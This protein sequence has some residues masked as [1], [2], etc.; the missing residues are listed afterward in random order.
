[1]KKTL[2][3]LFSTG[4]I[5]YPNGV[6]KKLLLGLIL[7]IS[8]FQFY[9][10]LF[11]ILDPFMHNAIFITLMLS[12]AFIVY[13]AN[14]N[15]KKIPWIDY[16]IS[17]FLCISTIFFT[18]NSERFLT[19]WP[20]ADLLTPLEIIMG[21]TLILI[22]I[23]IT[24]RTLGFG[25]LIIVLLLISYSFFGHLIPG[26]FGH[27]EISLMQ[28]IDQMVYTVNGI[29]GTIA[30]VAATYV[31]FFVFFG[32]VFNASGGGDFFYAISK[33]ITGR[34]AGG[35]AKVAVISS[36]LYGSIS[37]S[38]TADV[39][40]T[41]SFTIP[42]MKKVGYSPIYAGAIEATAATGGSILPP[43]MGS[44]AF[45]M[46][47]ITGIPY[48]SIAIAALVPALLYY[49]AIF[50]QVH[51][52][53][54]KQNMEGYGENEEI[55][56][57]KIVMKQMGQYIIPILVLVVFLERGSSPV[58][59]AVYATVT[60]I[61]VSYFKKETRMSVK[62]IFDTLIDTV[63]RISP[64]VAVCAAAGIVT[65]AVQITG[66]AGKFSTLIHTLSGGQILLTL[67]V[68][69]IVCIIFGMGMPTPA[70]YVLTAV[71]AA[72]ILIET[73][74][75]L[76]QAHLF[77]LYY[78]CLSA[79]TPPVAVAGYAAAAIADANPIKISLLACRL[80]I[81]AF[82]IPYMFVLNPSII[83]I[84]SVGTIIISVTTAIIGVIGL[85]A[86]FEGW[87]IKDMNNIEKV[88]MIIASLLL[89]YPNLLLSLI[90]AILL[91]VVLLPKI[92]S[93]YKNKRGA[94]YE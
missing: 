32:N 16:G 10:V 54:K 12:I 20:L 29:F 73:G 3:N 47:E 58:L 64:L 21:I 88:V 26:T 86:G 35:P 83:L 65:G 84:G 69:M 23:E 38:P 5:R 44:A 61:I 82:I 34:V 89:I 24:R 50:F 78:A 27:Q 92:L 56:T 81:V 57:I 45:L 1:M 36:G 4:K 49:I 42:A 28:F 87:F 6:V 93:V 85:A 66:L 59:A 11:G 90:G 75:P 25:M 30:S 60:T 76:L 31:F 18:L 70:A 91:V 48:M 2:S 17:L 33:A 37:G 55:P 19:R 77:I 14:P 43:V 8:C 9:L 13:S 67:F 71:L 94:V 62:R 51:F 72:P 74:V 52:Q 79:I 41:G 15:S 7:I 80:G 68:T 39:A 53:A 22:V 40:T 63:I 46:A